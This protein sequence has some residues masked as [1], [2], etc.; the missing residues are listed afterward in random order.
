MERV[1]TLQVYCGKQDLGTIPAIKAA[2][3]HCSMIFFNFIEHILHNRDI[4][5]S[6]T[7]HESFRF[8]V[9]QETSCCVVMLFCLILCLK[10]D[11]YKL[12]FEHHDC[13]T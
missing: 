13:V 12:T 7:D 4:Y 8:S 1:S 3:F 10:W 6:A 2:L 9:V 11:I 5:H